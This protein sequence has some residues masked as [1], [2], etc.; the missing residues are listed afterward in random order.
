MF[1]ASQGSILRPLLFNA[2]ICDLFYEIQDLDFV[3]F[4]ND[5]TSYS[6]LSDTIPVLAQVEGSIGKIFDWFI[7]IFLKGNADKS[8]VN[9]SSNPV[10][11]GHKLNIHKTFYVRS[12]YVL[13]LRGKLLWTPRCQISQ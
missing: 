6:C 9:T 1:G 7:K 8:H 5:N 10:D 2:Y 4:T 13:C 12:I 11:T 3:N